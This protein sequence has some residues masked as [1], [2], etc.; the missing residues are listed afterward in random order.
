LE[1]FSPDTIQKIRFAQAYQDSLEEFFTESPPERIIHHDMDPGNYSVETLAAK[2][3]KYIGISFRQQFNFRSNDQAFKAWRHAL[4]EAGVF[5]FKDSF[6]DLFL[7][8]FCIVHDQYPIIMVNNSNS[9]TRQI[10]TLMHE[11]GHIL[12]GVNG[13]TD[14]DESY[15]EFLENDEQRIEIQCNRFAAEV[16]VPAKRFEADIPFFE[17]EGDNAISDLANKYSVSREVILRRLLD[18][19]LIDKNQYVDQSEEWNKDYLRSK[20]ETSGGNWY[21]TKMAYLGEGFVQTAFHNYQNGK[22]DKATLATHLN[23][24][25]KNL[26]KFESY[27]WR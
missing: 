20:K 4:E 6:K 13:V 12:Y 16:L 3:R 26:K 21:L 17:Q 25:A 11:L 7:S 2:V 19:N 23:V 24:K 27:I 18:F 15:L 10:F 5:K 8:G 9:F 22:F 1:R 14:V